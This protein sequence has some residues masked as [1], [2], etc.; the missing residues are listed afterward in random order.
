MVN[1]LLGSEELPEKTQGLLRSVLTLGMMISFLMSLSNTFY[2]VFV[3]DKIGYTLAATST[4]IMLLTQLIFDYPSGSLGDWIG[5][6]WVLA[7]AFITY[8]I[9][10]LFLISAQTFTDFV[11]I[12]I[13]NGFGNAQS[14]GAFATWIDNNYRKTVGGKDTDR[15]IYGFV[16]SRIG[17]FQSFALGV[18]F[19]LGGLFATLISREF[20][21]SIQ[22][23]LTIIVIVLI[24][25][26]IKDVK[27][28]EEI[29]DQ[30]KS[31]SNNY[32]EFLKGGINVLFSSKS[33]FL[34]LVGSAI[35]NTTWLI[36]GNLILFPIYFGYTGTDALASLLRTTL[37]FVGIPVSFYMANVSKKIA[38]DRLPLMIFLELILFFPSFFI[39]LYF[40]PPQNELNLIGVVGTFILLATLVGMLFNISTTLLQRITLDLV[41]SEN[42]NAVYSLLPSII[43]IFGIPIL[44]IAGELIELFGLYAGLLL[45]GVVCTV[46]FILLAIGVKVGKDTE[47]LDI[48]IDLTEE[49][50]PVVGGK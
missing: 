14:S 12:G 11:F 7:I 48:K 47:L 46:G 19:M 34:I 13:I 49:K 18:S 41:P 31:Q 43:S 21:F 1:R 44:P 50:T 22:F 25:I 8:W 38:N 3:I 23:Y 29:E 5:Q 26:F 42:R 16:M 30:K 27:M 10:F 9:N 35:Y 45:A 2:I 36:W 4:S 40:V 28:E 17:T 24:L 37:F 39:L 6:R 20:V 32:F 15:R 33:V